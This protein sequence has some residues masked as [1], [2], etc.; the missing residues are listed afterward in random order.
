MIVIH[1]AERLPHL[2]DVENETDDQE[3]QII[4]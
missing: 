4:C 3:E 2:H 1:L